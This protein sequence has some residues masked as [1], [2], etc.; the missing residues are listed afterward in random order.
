M[1]KL[2]LLTLSLTSLFSQ[3]Q[4]DTLAIQDF[5]SVPAAPTWNYTGTLA[6]TQSGYAAAGTSIP[7]S[8]LGID[9]STAWHVVSVSGGNPIVFNN[10]AIPAGYDSIRASFRLAAMDLVSSSGGPD[11]LDYVLFE[12]SLDGGNTFS[13][14]IRVR[15]AVAN[16]SFWPYDATGVA[17]ETYLPA[18]EVVY[19]PANTGLQNAEG[20]SFVEISFPGSI[21]QLAVR[22]TPR[23][24]S[25]TDSW[26]VDNVVLTGEFSCTPSSSSITEIACD[27]YISPSGATYTNSGIYTDVL[28]NASGCDSVIT[29]DLTVNT[30]STG[31]DI[32]EA[33]DS[34]TWIDGNTYLSN[35]FSATYLLTGITGCDSLVT[36]NLT[37]N[38]S[39]DNTVTQN[40][41]TLSASQAGALYQ[42]IDCDNGNQAIAGETN[43]SFT[44][45]VSGNYAVEITL[46]GCT[47]TSACTVIGYSGLDE[48]TPSEKTVIAVYDLLGRVTELTTHTPLIVLYSDGTTERIYLAE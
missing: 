34:Y 44:P 15:G 11:N 4:I 12:Y 8:P 24:S 33:C 16:N 45:T 25:S 13:P 10:M 31:T 19:N 22:I 6:G 37:I 36:L 26:L 48:L 9:G 1:K 30:S 46:S 18:S 47:V 35:N 14:R 41:S 7:G 20:Y 40:G 23:S 2:L 17:S 27:S 29:I 38:S 32:V 43:Q 28:P 21:T 42:W 5:E 3:A 39:P